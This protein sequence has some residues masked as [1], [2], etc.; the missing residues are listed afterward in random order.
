MCPLLRVCPQNGVNLLQTKLMFEGTEVK[1]NSQFAVFVTMNPNYAGRTELPDNLKVHFGWGW[2]RFLCPCPKGSPKRLSLVG[3]WREDRTLC[4]V[5]MVGY[6]CVVSWIGGGAWC[7]WQALFRPVAMM[8][9]D[10]VRISE[11]MLFSF[12][13]E[14]GPLC[15]RKMVATFKL[16]SEQL[17]NQVCVWTG[18]LG[19]DMDAC[20]CPRT[21]L[22]GVVHH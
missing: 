20:V 6:D 13:F 8:V 22:K 4:V 17:S 5:C 2:G 16:C 15:A 21:L 7:R 9:P 3:C 14:K 18:Q 11:I 19:G 12:G 10:Y 1:L